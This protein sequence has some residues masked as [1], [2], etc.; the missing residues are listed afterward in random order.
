MRRE[1]PAKRLGGASHG[2]QTA[3][4]WSSARLRTPCATRLPIL[5]PSVWHVMT[6]AGRRLV[7]MSLIC[8]FPQAIFLFLKEPYKQQ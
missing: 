2:G 6:A 3:V 8:R 1:L 7:V 4:P 5:A